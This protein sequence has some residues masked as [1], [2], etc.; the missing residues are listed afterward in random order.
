MIEPVLELK[1]INTSY[2]GVPVLRDINIRLQPGSINTVLGANGA[3]KSTLLKVIAGLVT[4]KSGS[5]LFRSTNIESKSADKIV[6]DG[7]SLVPE[8]R[9]LFTNM[10]VAENLE[11]GAYHRS[12]RLEILRDLDIVLSYFP[13]LRE[14][15]GARSG[16]LSGG[17]QQMLAIGRAIMS[18]PKLLMLDEPSVGLA[19]VI[20]EQIGGIIREISS[21]G[22]DVLLVEQNARLGL[23][24]SDYGY[25]LEGGRVV[26]EGS[27]EFLRTSDL[28][29]KVY[30]GL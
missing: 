3:G 10:T 1:D 5:I 22:V 13:A 7:I 12:D 25:V 29:N 19:P 28:I 20:V 24:V 2:D 23:K 26:L 4:E 21:A 30:I 6:H 9:R 27:S 15:L 8:G 11:I 16:N 14:R 18:R 17:Q